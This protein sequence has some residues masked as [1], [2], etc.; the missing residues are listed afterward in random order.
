MN[1]DIQFLTMLT[2][3]GGGVVMAALFDTYKLLLR[4]HTYWNRVIVDTLF[5]LTQGC[6]IFYLL[7]LANGGMIRFYLF[8]AVLLGISTYFAL[9]QPI[10]LPILNGFIRLTVNINQLI[11]RIV[12]AL[13]IKPIIWVI[14]LVVTLLVGLLA[15][16]WRLVV[17]IYK[18]IAFFIQPFIPKFVQNYLLNLLAKCSRIINKLK[19]DMFNL[20]KNRGRKNDEA[21]S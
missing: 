5:L 17:I 15:L 20:W 4:P 6:L 8:L 10:Y 3:V 9:L 7:F 11:S 16:I 1:L 2:M 18:I 12:R 19:L 21:D 13:I 14:R